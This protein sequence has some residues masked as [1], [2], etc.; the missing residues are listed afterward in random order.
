MFSVTPGPSHSFPLG[1][2][3]PLRYQAA[4]VLIQWAADG[5]PPAIEDVG[6]DHGSLHVFVPQQL[7]DGAN[8][9]TGF[10]EVGGEGV[11]EG[12]GG[13]R[14]GDAAGFGGGADGAL[15]VGVVGVMAAYNAAAGVYA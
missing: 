6:V 9:V 4:L 8:V 11:A 7:L 15:Q 2:L 1:L 10:Q 5:K 3:L 12:V 14:L 13:G